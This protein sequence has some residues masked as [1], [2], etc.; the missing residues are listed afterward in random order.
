MGEKKHIYIYIYIV[1]FIYRVSSM[2]SFGGG[3]R[4]HN[5]PISKTRAHFQV[6][7]NLALNIIT[8]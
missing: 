3:S 5:V 6:L 4:F 8:R 1:F 2:Y 7:C